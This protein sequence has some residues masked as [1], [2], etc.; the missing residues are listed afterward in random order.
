MSQSKKFIKNSFLTLL[1][2]IISILLGLLISIVIAR[3]LGPDG[4]GMYSLITLLP[5]M[6]YTFLNIGIEVSTVYYVGR[7]ETSIDSAYKTSVYSAIGLSLIGIGIGLIALFFFSDELFPGISIFVLV[8]MLLVLPIYFMKQFLQSIFQGK[9][10]FKAFN[11]LLILGQGT[12]F[13]FVF[14]FLFVLDLGLY[15]ALFSFALGQLSMLIVALVMLKT[16]LNASFKRGTFS[17]R[18]LK[19]SLIYGL[20]A[21]ISNILTFLNYRFDLILVG[22]FMNPAAVGLYS[23]AVS[24]AEKL[25]ILSKSASTVLFPRIANSNDEADRNHVTSVV[26]RVVLAISVVGGIGFFIIAGIFIVL[27]FGTEYSG[28]TLALRIML[29]GIILGSMERI[30]SNDI[31]GRGKPEINMY[32]SILSVIL[33]IGL[34]IIFIPLYGIEGA[35]LAT[36]ITY[37]V[38]WIIKIIIFNRITGVPYRE[39]ILLKKSDIQLAIKLGKQIMVRKKNA[40]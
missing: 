22:L 28:S 21:H 17:K 9:E 31:S 35:A 24:V 20:K 38:N 11:Y 34:N 13:I 16:R 40:N 8:A 4:Q 7:G 1:R 25:W 32:T 33:N 12:T 36:T 26:S 37:T 19:N 18:F 15:F 30:L 39:F 10:D 3:S 5:M 23:I 29:L 27:M 6:L 14:I 2:Q